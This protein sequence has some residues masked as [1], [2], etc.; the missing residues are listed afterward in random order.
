MTTDPASTKQTALERVSSQ[1]LKC[2]LF[3]W[4]P[5][6]LEALKACF[7]R[8]TGSITPPLEE[9]Y[10]RFLVTFGVVEPLFRTLPERIRCKLLA[11]KNFNLFLRGCLI[12][13][14]INVMIEDDTGIMFEGSVYPK[15]DAGDFAPAECIAFRAYVPPQSSRVLATLGFI[16][17]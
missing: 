8:T 13:C 5:H 9:N 1:A 7:A 16:E 2:H 15:T 17:H 11:K 4:E 14:D 12:Y 10:N 6:E 3:I